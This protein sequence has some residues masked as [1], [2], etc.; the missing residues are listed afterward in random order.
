MQKTTQSSPQLTVFEAAQSTG[1][2][3]ETIYRALTLGR[4]RHTKRR[5]G[6]MVF[7]LIDKQ[8]LE[9]YCEKNGRGA[10]DGK[11]AKQI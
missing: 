10:P 9:E 2:S 3:R 11:P 1:Y 5:V 4:I 6:K 8:S 7:Y